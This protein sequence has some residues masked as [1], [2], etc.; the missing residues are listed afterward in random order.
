MLQ[1][2]KDTPW[3]RFMKKFRAILIAGLAVTV[4]IGL[5]VWIFL[6]LFES[7]DKILQPV[8]KGIFGYEIT[9]VG[10]GVTVVLVIVIGII[11]TNVIGKRIVRW[12]ESMLSKVPI[13]KSLYVAIKQ[14]VQSFTN[15]E[16]TGFLQV[17]LI[18][19]PAKGMKTIAFVTNE[20]I[21]KNGRK[22]INLF[23]PTAFNPT[24]GFMEIVREVD[25]VRTSISVE[26]GL[27]LMVSGGSMSPGNLCDNVLKA[28]EKNIR[29]GE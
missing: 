5:T 15:P 13:T 28:D 7:I 29:A 26:D 23:V 6:W 12:G 16:K 24:G 3:K 4:P 1:Q 22:L 25:I 19:F 14:I 20:Q 21:D 11:T 9:G 8:V 2:K 10:F 27:K 17:V 18:E